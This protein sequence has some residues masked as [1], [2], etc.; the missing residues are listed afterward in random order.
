MLQD[1][2][3]PFSYCR[4]SFWP[5]GKWADPIPPRTPSAIS[6]TKFMGHTKLQGMISD[7]LRNLMGKD[8]VREGVDM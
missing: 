3:R 4:E 6:L 5:E 2:I 7:D 8:T 1:L